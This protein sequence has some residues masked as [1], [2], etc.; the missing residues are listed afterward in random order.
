MSNKTI[1]IYDYVSH[2]TFAVESED[3]NITKT[4]STKG[5]SSIK[6]P[7]RK[8]VCEIHLKKDGKFCATHNIDRPV[9]F[10]SKQ[11]FNMVTKLPRGKWA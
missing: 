7:G 3:V 2:R 4:K 6:V 11:T 1:K 5:S 9:L 10:T 8:T